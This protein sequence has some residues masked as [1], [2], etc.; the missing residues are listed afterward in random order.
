MEEH[1]QDLVDED[2]NTVFADMSA[3]ER[4]RALAEEADVE[5]GVEDPVV[6]GDEPLEQ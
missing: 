1:E 3:Q 2:G 4:A 5:R 6:P